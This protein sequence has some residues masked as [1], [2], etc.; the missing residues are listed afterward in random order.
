MET[1]V[2]VIAEAMRCHGMEISEVGVSSIRGLWNERPAH[3]FVYRKPQDS[4]ALF[5]FLE[6]TAEIR[7][8]MAL[9]DIEEGLSLALERE[10]VLV[11]N[12]KE[13]EAMVGRC[14][15]LVKSGLKLREEL[16]PE[17]QGPP[18]FFVAPIE[19]EG[20]KVILPKVTRAE[21]EHKASRIGGFEFQL[22]L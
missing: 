22:I 3:I 5:L 11:L 15:L 13:V 12:R 18:E 14:T 2:E 16:F 8:V 10:K 1:P 4:D 7:A 19:I 6:E 17:P 9:E 21:A 20:E